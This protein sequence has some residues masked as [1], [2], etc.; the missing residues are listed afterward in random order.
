[1]IRS[2]RTGRRGA[3]LAGVVAVAGLLFGCTQLDRAKPPQVHLLDMR[4]L[5]GGLFA[6]EVELSLR[7]GNP[8]NFDVPLE[9]M[10]FT[11]DVNGSRLAEGY[12]NQSFTLPRLGEVTVP[13]RATTTLADLVEQAIALGREG[14][15]DYAIKGVAYVAGFTSRDVPYEQTGTLKL[16]PSGLGGNDTGTDIHHF[17]PTH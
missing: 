3:G 1:M 2:E 4:F 11:L 13:V 5:G 14:K 9:G 6:Q 17:S 8:N 16:L 12:T 7:V 10:T 15:L